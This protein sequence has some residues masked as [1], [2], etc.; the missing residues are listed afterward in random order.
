MIGL[1]CGSIVIGLYLIKNHLQCHYNVANNRSPVSMLICSI[2]IFSLR[3]VLVAPLVG[4]YAIWYYQSGIDDDAH[5][6]CT[7]EQQC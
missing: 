7:C 4:L 2:V 6:G 5:S 1:C 3:C